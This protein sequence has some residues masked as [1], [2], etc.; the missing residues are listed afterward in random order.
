MMVASGRN[1]KNLWGKM[2]SPSGKE[3][4]GGVANISNSYCQGA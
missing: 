2:G 1:D 4:F 3:S